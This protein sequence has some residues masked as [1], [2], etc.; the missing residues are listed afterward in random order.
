MR[1]SSPPLWFS[2]CVAVALAC[3]YRYLLAGLPD[4]APGG[5]GAPAPQ[6][7]FWGLVIGIVTWIWRGI[8]AAGRVTLTAVAYSVKLLWTFAGKVSNGLIDIGHGLLVGL[9]KAWE[10]FQLT[11]ERVIKPAWSKFWRWFDKFRR[12]MDETIGP[13]LGWLRD[14][15][16]QLLLF[17]KT[18]VRPWLDL[19]D[20]TRRILRVLGSLGLEWA[21][22]LDK[23][24]AELEERIERPFRVLVA[25]VNEVINLV[26]RVITLDGLIQRIAL[27]RSLERDVRYAWRAAVNWRDD[28]LTGADRDTMKRQTTGRTRAQIA[29][30]FTAA[31]EHGGGPYAATIAEAAT[32]WRLY[33]ER[34]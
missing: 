3:V 12:W 8:E 18:Y 4:T 32:A 13:I 21:R 7:A 20:V 30:D 34:P 15:R 16:D 5:D 27:I 28:P 10:F 11:Y 1:R 19:I 31:A 23:K 9:R 25:K 14:L 22:A 29:A 24:L 26:N 6:I 17:W 2:V 33:L